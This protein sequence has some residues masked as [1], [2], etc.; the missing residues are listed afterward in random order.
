MNGHLHEIEIMKLNLRYAHTRVARPRESLALADSI[1]RI[2]QIVP[3]VV[4]REELTLIDGYLRVGAM[5]RLGRD[6]VMA[7]IR[8]CKEEDALAAILA[9][10][11]TWDLLEEAALLV[12]L[13]ENCNLSQSKIAVMVGRTQGWV[14]TRLSLYRSLSED[15]IGMIRKGLISTWTAVRVIIPIA[16]AIPE[17][18]RLL[19]EN[20]SRMSVT[21][22]EMS[23]FFSHYQKA[24]RRQRERMVHEPA[25]F[26]KSLCARE[27]ALEAKALK[28]GMEGKWVKDLRVITHM[29]KGLIKEVPALFGQADDLDR[30]LLLTA[31]EDARKQFAEIEHAIRRHE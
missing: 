1:E 7:E 5:R 24:T 22:R 10:G 25:L 2:G 11:R 27:E 18:G 17:H 15:L 31:F 3:V 29:F 4:T 8:E 30:R 20:L 13:H 16:R 23:Q 6:T 28:E 26:L 9:H 21:T 12:A 19:S 14:S